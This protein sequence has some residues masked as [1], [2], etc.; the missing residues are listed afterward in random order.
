MRIEVE[1]GGGLELIATEKKKVHTCDVNIGGGG[2]GGDNDDDDDKKRTKTTTIRDF[3]PWVRDNVIVERHE[4][5]MKDDSVYVILIIIIV[6]L[7]HTRARTDTRITKD[8]MYL[9][10]IAI[11][12]V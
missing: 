1:L 2:G 12:C 4:L 10:V 8:I 3:L 7:T 6:C 9:F 11:V 5:F